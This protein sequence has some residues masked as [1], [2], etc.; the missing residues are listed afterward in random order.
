M[1][2]KEALEVMLTEGWTKQE[3]LI[4]YLQTHPHLLATCVEWA[5]EAT[6]PRGW[7]AAWVLFHY[8][9]NQKQLLKPHIQDLLDAIPNK[10]N[11]QQRELLKLLEFMELD[12][13]QEGQFFDHCMTIWEKIN[14]SSSLRITAFR[15]LLQIA[16]RYPE[17]KE[18]LVLFTGEDYSSTLSPGILQSFERLKKEYLQK[19]NN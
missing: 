5:T 2:E 19:L 15:L 18:E 4:P 17:L 8:T 13:L 6:A 10:K 9:K 1:E 16:A 14:N 11:G 7:R 3:V 12:D